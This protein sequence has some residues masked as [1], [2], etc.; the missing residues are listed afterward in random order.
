MSDEPGLW[1][2][3]TLLTMALLGL[4]IALVVGIYKS[5]GVM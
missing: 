2:A 4:A 1:T 5:T 3:E